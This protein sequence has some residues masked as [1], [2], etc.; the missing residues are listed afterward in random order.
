MI[1]IGLILSVF[2][3]GFLC[4]LLFTL[5]VYA[6]PFFA[7]MTAGLAAY[8]SGAGV[9]GALVVGFAAGAV[10]LVAGQAAFAAVKSPV[11]TRSD[12]HPIRGARRHCRLPRNAGAC[13]NRRPLDEPGAKSFAIVGAMFVGGTAF[14]RMAAMA[15]SPVTRHVGAVA[16]GSATDHGRDK[17]SGKAGRSVVSALSGWASSDGWL[18]QRSSGAASSGADHFG[19]SARPDNRASKRRSSLCGV[20]VWLRGLPSQRRGLFLY[21]RTLRP[22]VLGNRCRPRL[23]PQI[24][25]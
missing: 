25:V 9:L 21:A 13:P 16:P 11:A 18:D 10:T 1:V 14:V 19:P 7:G 4:W 2:G 6:L 12:R 22:L 23:L 15:T 8:H 3:V 24:A 20:L 17:H 5:A